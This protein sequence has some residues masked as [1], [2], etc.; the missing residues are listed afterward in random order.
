MIDVPFA[1][2][3]GP[4]F[5]QRCI[6]ILVAEDGSRYVGTNDVRNPQDYCPRDAAGDDRG[7]GYDKCVTICRQRGHSEHMAIEAALAAGVDTE[8]S[9]IYLLG[10]DEVGGPGSTYPGRSVCPGCVSVCDAAG[11]AEVIV[12]RPPDE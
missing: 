12:G 9:R 2:G 11:V 7:H 5:K 1:E 8:G 6:S 10:H 4:C 3:E